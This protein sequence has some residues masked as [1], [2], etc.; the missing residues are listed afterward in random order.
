MAYVLARLK[1]ASTWRGIA[2]LLTAFGVQVAP[3]VQEAVISAGVAV[4]G[5]IGVFFP[6]TTKSWRKRK[7]G[8][9]LDQLLHSFV[10]LRVVSLLFIC[11][12]LVLKPSRWG[13]FFTCKSSFKIDEDRFFGVQRSKH[14]KTRAKIYTFHYLPCLSV[15]SPCNLLADIKLDT[16]INKLPSQGTFIFLS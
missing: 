2:L 3:E 1:E 10:W 6:D 11:L 12:L 7:Q 9:P 8:L 14:Y 15:K 4:A 13:L 5:A 16:A